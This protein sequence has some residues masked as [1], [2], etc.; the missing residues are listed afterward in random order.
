[1]DMSRLFEVAGRVALVTGASSGLGLMI[2]K[3]RTLGICK[4]HLK[5]VLTKYLQGLVANGVKTYITALPEKELDDAVNELET[6]A[7]N[8]GGQ[9][10][11]YAVLV[12][13]Q[14][15]ISEKS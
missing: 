9:V 8:S 14:T 4:E 2:A 3:V 5:Y 7:S 10:I 13:I 11:G 1:M 15:R 6:I 12:S